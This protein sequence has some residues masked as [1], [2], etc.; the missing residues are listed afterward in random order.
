MEILAI[1][2]HTNPNI[3]AIHSYDSSLVIQNLFKQ[4]PPIINWKSHRLQGFGLAMTSN[5]SLIVTNGEKD[6]IKIWN[7]KTICSRQLRLVRT[8]KYHRKIYFC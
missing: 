4:G 6:K 7:P 5:S 8:F 3:L 1:A 2:I